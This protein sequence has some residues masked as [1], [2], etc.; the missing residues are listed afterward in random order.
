MIRARLG[1]RP[2]SRRTGCQFSLPRRAPFVLLDRKP[3]QS[4]LGRSQPSTPIGRLDGV[5]GG[6]K[7]P[8]GRFPNQT[9]IIYLSSPVSF[10]HGRWQLLAMAAGGGAKRLRHRR[11]FL[12][13]VRARRRVS[14]P[15]SSESWA[16]PSLAR[17]RAPASG[18]PATVS[19]NSPLF[20][21]VAR[22]AAARDC[23]ARWWPAVVAVQV[24]TRRPLL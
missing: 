3:A 24:S 16:V 20:C 8:G 21:A 11:G 14:A 17:P 19:G 22:Q 7:S 15:P 1:P 5:C 18:V 6:T 12:A 13:G 23:P 2:N 4:A 10:A 9:L